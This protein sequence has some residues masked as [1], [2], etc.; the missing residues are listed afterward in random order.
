MSRPFSESEL[1]G[2][3][4]QLMLGLNYLH[5]RWIVHRDLKP[6]NLLIKAGVVKICD[7]GLGRRYKPFYASIYTKKVV[8]LWY[9]APEVLVGIGNYTESIDIWSV[10]CIFAEIVKRKPLFA[11]DGEMEVLSKMCELLGLP[12]E[13]TWPDLIRLPQMEGQKFKIHPNP[14]IR[15]I[16]SELKVPGIDLL[17]KLIVWDPIRRFSAKTALHHKYF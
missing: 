1:K 17:T 9:R 13:K 4:M 8:T 15:A 3:L 6:S 11:A 2:I 5:K 10:G 12:N 16:F 7:F 14:H